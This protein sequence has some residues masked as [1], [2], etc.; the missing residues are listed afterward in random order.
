MG[1]GGGTAAAG[2]KHRKCIAKQL[3]SEPHGKQRGGSQPVLLST[4]LQADLSYTQQK[5]CGEKG[6]EEGAVVRKR[7]MWH[8]E[9]EGCK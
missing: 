8:S 5:L 1:V 7:E 3:A 4:R 6:V 9:R 2:G